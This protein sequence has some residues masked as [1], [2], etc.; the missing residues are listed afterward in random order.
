MGHSLVA[1]SR[2]DRKDHVEQGLTCSQEQK[3]FVSICVY[4]HQE[5]SGQETFGESFVLFPSNSCKSRPPSAQEAD[6]VIQL[7]PRHFA[8]TFL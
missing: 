1:R 5:T 8:I 3:G 7:P 4:P 6:E 2:N